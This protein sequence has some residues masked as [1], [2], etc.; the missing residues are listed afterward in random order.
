MAVK[1]RDGWRYQHCGTPERLV[2]NH[3]TPHDRY[4][5]TFFDMSNLGRCVRPTTTGSGT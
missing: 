4:P 3:R 1:R 5:G 2:V